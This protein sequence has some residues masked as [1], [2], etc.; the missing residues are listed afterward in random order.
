MA[1]QHHYCRHCGHVSH[2]VSNKNDIDRDGIA[3]QPEATVLLDAAIQEN[4]AT[5]TKASSAS[6]L[7]TIIESILRDYFVEAQDAQGEAA[8][9]STPSSTNGEVR[10]ERL[11]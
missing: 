5:T 1:M 7:C 2:R 10:C 8:I 3:R 6:Y 9:A 11:F 4:E